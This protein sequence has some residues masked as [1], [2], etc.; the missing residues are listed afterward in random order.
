MLSGGTIDPVKPRDLGL[1]VLVAL[2]W[3]VN[4]V[5]IEVGLDSMPPLLFVTLRFALCAVPA[6]FLVGRPTV[7]WRW[8]VAVA[9]SLAVVKFPLLFAGM[10]A[11][12]PA[13][14]S[15]LVLQS[16]A[17]FTAV[18][19]A[20]LLRERP[21]RRAVTGLAVATAGIV[22]LGARLGAGRPGAAFALVVAAGAAWGLANV[23]MRRAAAPDLLNFMVW[24]SVV[25]TPMLAVLSLAVDGPSA[26]AAAVRALD[27]GAVGAIVYVAVL[28]TLFGFGAW[29]ML[30]RRYGAATVAPFAMLAP[31]FALA[32]SAVLLG[33]EVGPVQILG[34]AAV[35]AGVLLG[36]VPGSFLPRGPRRL[37][38]V[39]HVHLRAGDGGRRARRDHS[40]GARRDPVLGGHRRV[41]D[42]R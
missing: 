1:A 12:M 7:A 18:F 15:A 38:F 35:L 32:S 37:R 8:V 23:A 14:L 19:A 27:L 6:V 4:F 5:V 3:G 20:A 17:V 29:G 21:G 40:D 9:V 13:G 22:L 30:M 36:A 26:V 11:G 42:L 28:S 16:Q 31:V 10:A 25:A 41:G 24:V 39:D 2:V 33:E 34:G